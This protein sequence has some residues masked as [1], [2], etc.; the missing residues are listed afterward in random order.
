MGCA[1]VLA[2]AFPVEIAPPA[3]QA[4]GREGRGTNVATSLVSQLMNEFRGDTLNAVASTLGE[5][6]VRTQSALGG[7]LPALMGGIDNKASTVDAAAGLLDLM[8]RNNLDSATFADVS[9]AIKAP[10]GINGLINLGRPLLDTLFGGRTGS[11]TDWVSSLS[12]INRT[13]SSSLLGL[14]MPIVL[15]AIAKR[16]KSSGWSASNLMSLLGEQRSFMGDAPAGLAALL[17]PDVEVH[18]DRERYVGASRSEP[19]YHEPVARAAPHEP[20]QAY[21]DLRRR[22][23]PW[24]WALPLLILIPI[25]GYL[26]TRGNEARRVADAA[27]VGVQEPVRPVGTSGS[28]PTAAPTESGSYVLVFKPGT[29]RLT[30]DSMARLEEVAGALKADPNAHADVSGY[31]DSTGSDAANLR[32]SQARAAA[33]TN[34]I[35]VLGIDKSRLT[36]QGF[37]A[38]DPVADNGSA[39]GRQQNR[40]VVITVTD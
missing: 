10:G 11:V 13:S 7:A 1:D 38:Q 18:D 16:L 40:R 37:G 9:S 29:S 5:S 32:L 20:L 35:V 12:G 31:T 22:T 26:L 36:P 25:L 15:G 8:K 2:A 3:R 14:A 30:P 34:R 4:F 33:A 19:V 17:R 23:S 24:L 21:T 28:Q 27:R 6:A 39:Q